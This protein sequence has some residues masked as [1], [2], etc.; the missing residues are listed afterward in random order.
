MGILLIF[1][2]DNGTSPNDLPKCL[3]S[4]STRVIQTCH[5]ECVRE[6][7]STEVG[8]AGCIGLRELERVMVIEHGKVSSRFADAACGETLFCYSD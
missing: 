8:L 3:L 2:Y 6:V 4:L 7:R 1:L 5:H